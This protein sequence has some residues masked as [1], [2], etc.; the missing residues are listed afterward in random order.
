MN[1]SGRADL[2]AQDEWTAG[3]APQLPGFNFGPFL[4]PKSHNESRKV[5]DTDSA[6]K[7]QC[8]LSI[9]STRKK[10][11]RDCSVVVF[12]VTAAAMKINFKKT[13]AGGKISGHTRTG[14]PGNWCR[15]PNALSMSPSDPVLSLIL[16]IGVSYR[17]QELPLNQKTSK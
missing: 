2:L 8:K 11:H 9:T 10:N 16:Q 7:W 4:F 6:H 17:A 12:P 14:W 15:P 3:G 5:P 13:Q 1:V